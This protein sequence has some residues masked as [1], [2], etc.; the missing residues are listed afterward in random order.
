MKTF[1]TLATFLLVCFISITG[2]KAQSDYRTGI[3]FRASPMAG[4][5]VKHFISGDAAIEGILSSRWHG[6]IFQGLYEVHQDVF[7]DKN[8]NFFMAPA[9][10]SAI[11][12]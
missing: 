10:T 5:S 9:A 8:F 1:R 11:G 2:L 6:T 12:I 3:G 7:N 4:L